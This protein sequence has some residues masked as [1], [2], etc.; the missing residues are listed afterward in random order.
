MC[1]FVSLSVLGS[2]NEI[3]AVSIYFSKHYIEFNLIPSVGL[4]RSVVGGFDTKEALLFFLCLIDHWDKLISLLF[5]K[6]T[7]VHIS[8][9]GNLFCSFQND[10]LILGYCY[11]SF[12]WFTAQNNHLLLFN[13]LWWSRSIHPLSKNK[14]SWL[15][16]PSLEASFLLIGCPSQT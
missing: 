15:P 11:C 10:I 7:R 3:Q 1:L 14:L 13:G 9:T 16:L 2:L 4:V 12:S 8:M 6:M 5:S